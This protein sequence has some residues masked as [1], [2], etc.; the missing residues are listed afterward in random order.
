M[1]FQLSDDRRQFPVKL[2][3]LRPSRQSRLAAVFSRLSTADHALT[4]DELSGQR[5]DAERGMRCLDRESSFE[6][7]RDRDILEQSDCESVSLVFP[8]NAIDRPGD[9]PFRQTVALGLRRSG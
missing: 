8:G 7:I 9:G 5:R 6:I 1:G 3:D 4:A 2:C